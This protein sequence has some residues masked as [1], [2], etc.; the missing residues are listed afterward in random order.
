MPQ[1]KYSRKPETKAF[2]LFCV[3][4]WLKFDLGKQLISIIIWWLIQTGLETNI[5]RAK[6][7]NENGV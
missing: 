6:K 2:D 7:V 4:H 3:G 5:S 1:E